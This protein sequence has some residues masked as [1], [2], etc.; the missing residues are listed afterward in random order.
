MIENFKHAIQEEINAHRVKRKFYNIPEGDMR[1]MVRITARLYMQANQEFTFDTENS[2]II[3]QL[4]MYFIG[5]QDSELDLGKGIFMRGPIGSGKSLLFL[6]FRTI[7]TKL[8]MDSGFVHFPARGIVQDFMQNGY[9][10]FSKYG[11]RNI[12]IDDIGDEPTETQHYGSMV[13]VIENLLLSRYFDWQ[14]NGYVTHLTTNYRLDNLREF[15]GTRITS[16]ISEMC[17]EVVL[18]SEDRRQK[19][20]GNVSKG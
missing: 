5:H 4:M 10:S 18:I 20:K 15:Y 9:Q 13:N 16:R 6:I 19:T 12:C 2:N 1:H 7:T 3:H 17:N 14:R 8:E 11:K